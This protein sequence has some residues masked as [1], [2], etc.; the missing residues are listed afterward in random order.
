[1]AKEKI[2]FSVCVCLCVLV[3]VCVCVLHAYMHIYIHT[4]TKHMQIEYQNLLE[5]VGDWLSQVGESIYGTTKGPTGRREWGVTTVG[6]NVSYLRVCVSHAC[7]YLCMNESVYGHL[8]VCVCV[9][10]WT[11]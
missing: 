11:T 2:S 8:Y 7:M 3:C 9:Y 5:I 1:M 4:Y 6:P 10:V